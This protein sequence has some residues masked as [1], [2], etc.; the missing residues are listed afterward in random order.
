M[1]NTDLTLTILQNIRADLAM[2]GGR[3]DNLEGRFGKLEGRFDKLE[4]R[5]GK[6][7]GRFD[8]LDRRFD[9]VD[10]RFDGLEERFDRLDDRSDKHDERSGTLEREV[11]ELRKDVQACVTRDEFRGAMTAMTIVMN[12]RFERVE[13]RLIE[14]DE[15]GRASCRERV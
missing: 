1:E 6:L 7:E 3:T 8:I 14:I 12:E 5:F 9:V 2:L 13:T 10:R 4:G 15:I 11:V